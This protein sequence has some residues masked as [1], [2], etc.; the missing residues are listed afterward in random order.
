[1]NGR[2]AAGEH[3]RTL[4]HDILEDE[5][6]TLAGLFAESY[7]GLRS[8]L[9]RRLIDECGLSLQWFVL[10]LRIARSPDRR[11]RMSDLADQ[12]SLTPSGL[13]RAIDR[14][15]EAGLVERVACPSDRR[16]AFAALTPLGLGRITA[17]VGP[18]LGHLD[19]GLV[20]LLS[21]EERG[22]LAAIL[23]KV[24][25]H[26]NPGA[27]RPPEPIPEGQPVQPVQPVGL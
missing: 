15:A 24:R 2:G 19:D 4:E 7:T 9:D 5:R 12:T 26:V 3:R 17:A 14:L 23:R 18:H 10:L 20:G 11:L 25:D 6:L 8:Q 16:G 21:D 13:T 1:M 27:A 22:Q